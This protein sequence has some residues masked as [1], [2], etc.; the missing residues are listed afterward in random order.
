MDN[1]AVKGP[2]VLIGESTATRDLKID[3]NELGSQEH[4]FSKG[5]SVAGEASC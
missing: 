4:L 1:A 3:G 2:C 5:H